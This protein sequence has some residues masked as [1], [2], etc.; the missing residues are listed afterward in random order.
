MPINANP[1]LLHPSCTIGDVVYKRSDQ[2]VKRTNARAMREKGPRPMNEDTIAQYIVDTFEGVQIL[3]SKGDTFFFYDPDQIFPFATLVTDDTHDQVSNL[4]RPFVFRLNIGVGKQTFRS[5]F[6]AL[7]NEGADERGYDFT[8]LDR[9]MPHPV[10][11]KMYWVCILSP[12]PET[13]QSVV[14]PLLAEA[15]ERDVSKHTKRGARG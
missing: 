13:F 15:Y 5:L 10:Y 4:A 2:P 8:A 6:G 11:G 14:Q 1:Q 7:T 3:R 12:S 9:L